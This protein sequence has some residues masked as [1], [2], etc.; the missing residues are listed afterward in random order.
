MNDNPSDAE[1]R[2][3]AQELYGDDGYIEIDSDA[4]ISQ[5]DDP[6]AYVAAWVWVPFDET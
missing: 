5:G 4:V 6:G 3:K 2:A 1:I